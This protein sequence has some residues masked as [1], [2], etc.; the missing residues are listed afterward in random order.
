MRP[1]KPILPKLYPPHS[2][3]LLRKTSIIYNSCAQMFSKYSHL[4]H[5]RL[6]YEVN[7][8]CSEIRHCFLNTMPEG[9]RSARFGNSTWPSVLWRSG[10]GKAF[11]EVD[12]D[13]R[14]LPIAGLLPH[15]E[16][17]CVCVRREGVPVM[18]GVGWGHT[19]KQTSL[20]CTSTHVLAHFAVTTR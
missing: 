7:A 2:G 11:Y 3:L 9:P 12:S 20:V 8:E 18:C 15:V 19:Q 17:V 14:R 16:R 13:W 1:H 4:A 10:C 6:V 5:P